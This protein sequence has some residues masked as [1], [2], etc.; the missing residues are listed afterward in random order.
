MK[1]ILLVDDEE[2]MLDLLSIYLSPYYHCIKVNSGQKAI[3]YLKD[4]HADLILLDIMMPEMDGWSTCSHIR[5]FSTLPIIM[6]TARSEK[7]DVVKGL[8]L[9]ADDYVTKP[10][11]E[12]ELL[13]RIDALF[14]RIN[15]KEKKRIHFK[16][17]WWDEE[18]HE[19]TYEKHI[20]QLTPKEFSVIGLLLKNPNKV[21]SRTNLLETVWG[22]NAFIEDRTIDSH[23]RNIRE[24]L[25]QVNFPI[26][27]YLATVWG[28][29][30]KWVN[31]E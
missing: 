17:L 10:F 1:T 7:P 8:Q 15:D 31:K 21:F 26:D 14:R 30:Y 13:A 28:V 5:R 29:G 25:R 4:S 27:Q 18:F 3:D 23:V 9:G 22:N 24:K 19:L 20:I 6:I 16:G 2:R 11:D 12:G